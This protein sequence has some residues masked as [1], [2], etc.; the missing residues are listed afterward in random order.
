MT[1]NHILRYA[2]MSY[3]LLSPCSKISGSPM[4]NVQRIL[5]MPKNLV[6][7]LDSIFEDSFEKLRKRGLARRSIDLC[8]SLDAFDRL[9]DLLERDSPVIEGCVVPIERLQL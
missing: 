7:N 6:Q 2:M 5:K 8:F 1:L 9:S 4:R 3:G